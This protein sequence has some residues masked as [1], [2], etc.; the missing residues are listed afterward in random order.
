MV[1]AASGTDTE[2]FALALRHLGGAADRPICNILIAPEETGRGVPMAARGLHFAVDTALGHDVTFQAPVAGFRPDTALVNISLRGADGALREVAQIEA[3][4][5]AAV[6]DALAA[7]RR[8]ILHALD[9]S[10][11]GLLAPSPDFLRRL[12]AEQGDAVDLVVDAC[13]ARLSPASLRHYLA[14]DAVVLITG[15]KFLTGPP[16]AGAAILP[17]AI[18]ARLATGT[19]PEGLAAY[20]GRHE[21]PPR[22]HAARLLPA[23]GNV[24]LALRWHAA[25]A[26]LRAFLRTPAERRLAILQGF[27]AC[28]RREIAR[29]PA[30][31][32]IE[33]PPVARGAADEAWERCPTIFT[34]SLRGPHA[35][36]RC[37]TPEEARRVYLWLN[38]DLSELLPAAAAVAA[39]IC[40]I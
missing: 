17:P 6:R 12:R 27:E 10:K 8:V 39:R 36:Q 4:I 29:Y 37:L 35:P 14:L 20:F 24:G 16:F 22:C 9:L 7:G 30:L 31:A 15:S 33:P 11:T 40:H 38:T 32:L 18:A 21:F 26:E 1:L 3:E 19:L 34:F 28:V 23:V 5:E 25:L 13:Q 2:L